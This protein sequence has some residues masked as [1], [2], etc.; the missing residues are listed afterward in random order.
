MTDITRKA[1]K[2]LGRFIHPKLK[3]VGGVEIL[4]PCEKIAK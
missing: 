2:G 1:R 3:Q 4:T